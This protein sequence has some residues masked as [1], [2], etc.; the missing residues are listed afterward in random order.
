[1]E[2]QKPYTF[3]RSW[4]YVVWLLSRKAYT[5]H[6]LKERLLKKKANPQVIEQIIAK[7][8]EMRFV[9]DTRFAEQFISSRQRSKGKL[10]IKQELFQKGL[11]EA[12]VNQTLEDLGDEQQIAS[13]TQVLEKQLSKLQNVESRKRYAKAYTFLA[14]R[15]FSGDII[16][17]TLENSNL[18]D[19]SNF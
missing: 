5:T 16:R 13:A 19:E 7:L 12:I 10:K 8:E 18:F 9:D 14:R 6:Q 2:S 3:E 1:M 4:N 15:G 17:S 11:S